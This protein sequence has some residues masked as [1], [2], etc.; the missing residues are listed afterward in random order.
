VVGSI[1]GRDSPT[2]RAQEPVAVDFPTPKSGYLGLRGGRMLATD[3][4]GR[5]WRTVSGGPRFDALAFVSPRVG[6]GLSGRLL[7]R[8]VDGARRWERFHAFPR[9]RGSFGPAGEVLSFVD[10]GHGWAVPA[11]GRLYRT[12]DGGRSWARV[13]FPCSAAEVAG[14]V[15][16]VTRKVGFAVCGGQPATIMQERSYYRTDDGG[17]RWRLTE[18]R[19]FTGHVSGIEY[20]SER[21]GFERASRLGVGRLPG[22][23]IVLDTNDIESVLSMSWPDAEHGFALLSHSGLVHTDDGGRHWQRVYPGSLPAPV[24]PLSFS[25]PSRGIGAVLSLGIFT[26]PGAILATDDGGASWLLRGSPGRREIAALARVSPSVVWAISANHRGRPVL[27]RSGDDGRRWR[28]VR[29]FPLGGEAWLS[30]P[31]ERDGFLGDD[32]G[33]LYRTSNGGRTWRALR[34]PGGV[35]R[36]V[37][38]SGSEG[39]AFTDAELLATPDG[40][41]TWKG[42]PVRGA[43]IAF[44]TLGAFDRQHIWVG[45]L[46]LTADCSRGFCPGLLLR[47]SDGGRHWTLIRLPS[48]IGFGGL[49]WVTPLVGYAPGPY[50]TRDGGRSWRYLLPRRM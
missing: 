35:G 5:S 25:S 2:A 33:H 50:R 39:L 46:D 44:R 36:A 23:E 9:G 13:G 17:D 10:R 48:L 43:S 38:L 24:G 7:F 26:R 14:G 45:G 1:V 6:F 12:R 29:S 3:D 47:T 4:S 8:T 16:F 20:L 27:F 30:F 21:V 42:V 22:H 19:I 18:R 31:R 32:R 40:G 34:Y 11:D 41:L 15:S 49:D 28:P 37:F